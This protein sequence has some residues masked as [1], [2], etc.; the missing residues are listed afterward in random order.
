MFT[1]TI[2]AYY[3][4]FDTTLQAHRYACDVFCCYV[5][6][7]PLCMCAHTTTCLLL[8]YYAYYMCVL[9]LLLTHACMPAMPFATTT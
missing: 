8:F 2:Y 5:C 7:F 1:Y 6:L 9:I 3:F 4:C